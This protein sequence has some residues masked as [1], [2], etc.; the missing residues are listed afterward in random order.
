MIY[1]FIPISRNGEDMMINFSESGHPVF[2]GSGVLPNEDLCEVKS[3]HPVF[4]GSSAN[5]DLCEAKEVEHFP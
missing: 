4:R 5:E 1:E 3:G 2:R